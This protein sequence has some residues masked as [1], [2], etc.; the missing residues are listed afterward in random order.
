MK[1]NRL[2]SLTPRSSGLGL[3]TLRSLFRLTRDLR[4]PGMRRYEHAARSFD[5]DG[6]AWG[7]DEEPPWPN[8]EHDL[9]GNVG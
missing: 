7:V 9:F 4:S 6:D 5:S 3:K 8:K 2:D 1:N